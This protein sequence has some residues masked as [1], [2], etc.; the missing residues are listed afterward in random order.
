MLD[1]VGWSNEWWH[2]LAS[3]VGALLP[4]CF[5]DRQWILASWAHSLD[6]I[7]S[8]DSPSGVLSLNL[9]HPHFSGRERSLTVCQWTFPHTSI[10]VMDRWFIQ[11]VAK[12]FF[13][14]LFPFPNSLQGWFRR[15]FFVTKTPQVIFIYVVIKSVFAVS[16]SVTVYQKLIF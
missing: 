8:L 16:H 5:T 1:F 2:P 6:V 3:Q 14:S 7:Y 15:W 12:Y 13:E 11:S 9:F 4:L 10:S